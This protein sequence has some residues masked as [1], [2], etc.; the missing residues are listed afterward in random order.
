MSEKKELNC[1]LLLGIRTNGY[2]PKGEVTDKLVRDKYLEMK[3]VLENKLKEMQ[4]KNANVLSIQK[5]QEFI[6]QLEEAYNK[7]ATK[8]LRQA[9]EFPYLKEKAIKTKIGKLINDNSGN[10][11]QKIEQKNIMKKSRAADVKKDNKYLEYTLEYEDEEIILFGIEKINFVNGNE[12]EDS[13]KNYTLMLKERDEPKPLGYDFYSNIDSER[14]KEKDYRIAIYQGIST[15]ISEKK[16]YMGSIIKEKS[17]SYFELRDGGQEDAAKER[18]V[19]K[20]KE[21]ERMI[22]EKE[23]GV[24]I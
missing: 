22:E 16:K 14:M 13:I 15:V 11:I 6:K 9:Y 21:R 10:T 7:I 17:G 5:L 20:I 3:E 19:Q 23:Q 24:Y 1:Y 4:A 18:E 2:L 12:Y 8:E